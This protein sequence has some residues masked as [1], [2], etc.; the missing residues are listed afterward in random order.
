MAADEPILIGAAAPGNSLDRCYAG[1][2]AARFKQARGT[3]FICV[4]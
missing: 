4:I 1:K 2:Y 3:E